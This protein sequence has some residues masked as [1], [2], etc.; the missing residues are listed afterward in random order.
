[1]TPSSPR[2][3]VARTS[4]HHPAADSIGSFGRRRDEPDAGVRDATDRVTAPGALALPRRF[5]PPPTTH[6]RAA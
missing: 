5:S 3:D 2:V 1:M 6:P 4:P